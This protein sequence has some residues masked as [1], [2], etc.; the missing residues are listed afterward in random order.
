M[1]ELLSFQVTK[2]ISETSDAITIL[3]TPAVRNKVQYR[4]GQF[5]TFLFN[6]GNGE[7]RR[8][9]SLSSSPDAD[10]TLSITVK[11]IVNGE[12]T[13]FLFEK[14]KEG[15]ILCALK[16]SGRFIFEPV[17][18]SRDIFLVAAGSGITPLF[19]I[20]KTALIK[21]PQS[22]I[23]LIYANRK[24]KNALFYQQLKALENKNQGR[25][26]CIFIFSEP[27]TGE[28]P[29]RGHLN[30]ELLPALIRENGKFIMEKAVCYICG[31]FTFMRMTEIVLKTNGFEEENI[32]KENFVVMAE[33]EAIDTPPEIIDPAEKKICIISGGKEYHLVAP[34]KTT[35]LKT[36][37]EQGVQVPYSCKSGICGTCA[38]LCREGVVK[39]SVNQ[40]LTDRDL[41]Q[42]W[43][44]TCVGYPATGNTLLEFKQNFN[45][46]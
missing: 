43:V 37:I 31:P 18:V 34:P 23:T 35:I 21:E 5:L 32:F 3:L 8:S 40:V 46:D 10:Q 19:S 12:V 44:L 39:M 1:E 28:S 36:A 41:R 30:V 42:G 45:P 9:Y 27:E 2:I 26:R 11:R 16:P 25:F 24:E 38:A 7:V 4:A 6:F 15:D 20:L 22:H 33:Q 17:T 13:S 14:L 29:Y